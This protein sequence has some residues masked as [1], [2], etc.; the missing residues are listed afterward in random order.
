MIVPDIRTL[1]GFSPAMGP[2][3]RVA[4]V[5]AYVE[6]NTLTP[7]EAMAI[8]CV[9]TIWGKTGTLVEVDKAFDA[10]WVWVRLT[11]LNNGES[12]RWLRLT[13]SEWNDGLF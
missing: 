3:E 10:G 7:G 6:A 12:S 2:D 4:L 11:N 1:P 8:G 9:V 13:E 5:N